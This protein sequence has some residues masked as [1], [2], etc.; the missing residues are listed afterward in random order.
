MEEL[1]FVT[2][3]LSSVFGCCIL[4]VLIQKITY[5]YRVGRK[6]PP[7]PIGLPFVGYLPFLGKEPHKALTKLKEK[8]GGLIGQKITYWYRV[9]RKKPPGPIGLPFLG[10]LPF[11][12]KEPHKALTK[13][14]EKYGGLIG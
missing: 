1:D 3:V 5:W 12:G 7:G 9:G 4:F 6:K 14:K 8:Y 13:L 11:L 10:Y 2:G